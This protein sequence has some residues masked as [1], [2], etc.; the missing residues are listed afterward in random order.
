MKKVLYW[1]WLI[2]SILMIPAGILAVANPS[3]TLLSLAWFIGLVML[4]EGG[5]TIAVYCY[6]RDTLFTSGW[7]LFDGIVT[8]ILAVFVLFYNV[9]TAQALPYA[10]GM[11]IIF[12]G[13]QRAVYAVDLK[14]I[15]VPGWGWLL[16]LGIAG[17]AF[18]VFSFVDPVFGSVA[19]SVM[20]GWFLIFYGVSSVALWT[21]VNRA[22]SFVKKTEKILDD[23]DA[24]EVEVR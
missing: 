12:S 9:F 6:T 17:A 7:M 21:R 23:S 20:V 8:V 3:S 4:I 1:L 2:F 5:V 11:W 18:G 19:L 15:G 10:F 16:G 13:L 14:H 22:R 24:I